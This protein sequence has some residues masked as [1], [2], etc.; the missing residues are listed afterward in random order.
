MQLTQFSLRIR[1]LLLLTV[2]Y[3][4]VGVILGVGLKLFLPWLYFA[5]F[6]LIPLFYLITG[7]ILNFVLDQCRSKR[8]E[9]LINAFMIMRMVKLILTV[10]FLAI[11][12]KFIGEHRIKFAITLVLFYVIYMSLESY[13]FYLYEKRRKK[14]ENKQS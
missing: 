5:H 3:T 4:S 7:V 11:Y 8:P 6:P 14:Y 10:A 12:D 1:L 9:R 2:I 13:L